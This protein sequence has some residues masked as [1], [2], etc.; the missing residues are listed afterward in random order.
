MKKIMR[1]MLFWLVFFSGLKAQQ[2]LTTDNEQQVMQSLQQHLAADT[3]LQ[4]QFEQERHLSIMPKAL[5]SKGVCLFRS[6][7]RLRWQVQEPWFSLLIYNGGQTAKFVRREGRLQKQQA[8]G[9]EIMAKILQQIA[10]WMRGDFNES[11]GLYALQ[12]HKAAKGWQLNLK[13]RSEKL[14]QTL[15]VIELHFDT[16]FDMRQVVI[17][18]SGE[19]FVRLRFKNKQPL[20]PATARL[21]DIRRPEQLTTN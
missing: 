14:R 9:A 8:G 3:A 16:K 2:V 18:E 20:P 21:F 13:P 12:M 11:Q 6:P 17:R 4:V 10:A 5:I 7:D 19:N 1:F 15:Q